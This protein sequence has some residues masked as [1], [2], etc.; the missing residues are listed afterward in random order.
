MQN[1]DI[2]AYYWPAYHDEPLWRRFMP[3]G[4]GEWQTIKKSIP[5]FEGHYQPRIPLWGYQDEADPKV[6]KQKINA[7]A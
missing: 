3:D 7:A 4:E 5:K 1:F 2:A 6:M